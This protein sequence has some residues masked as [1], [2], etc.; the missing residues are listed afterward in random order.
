MI[1]R[2]MNT[3]PLSSA[4]HRREERPK[5]TPR[6]TSDGAENG[7][8]GAANTRNETGTNVKNGNGD[9][10]RRHLGFVVDKLFPAVHAA[11]AKDHVDSQVAD[12]G[13]RRR[14][15]PHELHGRAGK[16]TKE[17]QDEPNSCR[18]N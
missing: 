14:C 13:V 18:S 5:T 1:E 3:D 6:R 16:R 15:G 9:R 12:L 2:N 10:E 11:L 8:N 4:R 17:A 7:E